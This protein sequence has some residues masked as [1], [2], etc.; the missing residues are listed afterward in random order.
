M[1]WS[2]HNDKAQQVKTDIGKVIGQCIFH[3]GAMQAIFILLDFWGNT[4]LTT[5]RSRVDFKLRVKRVLPCRLFKCGSP[6]GSV[7]Y[8]SGG[9]SDG[10]GSVL[11]TRVHMQPL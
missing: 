9:I 2:D 10:T 3:E 11:S 1:K 6:A 4:H 5:Y 8:L 7:C